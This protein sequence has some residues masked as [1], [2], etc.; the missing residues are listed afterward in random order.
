VATPGTAVFIYDHVS[1]R[2]RDFWGVT[3]R[4]DLLDSLNISDFNAQ[5]KLA[6]PAQSNRFSFRPLSLTAQY[7][8]WPK[9]VDLCEKTPISSLQEMRRGALI[10][11][12]RDALEKRMRM[13]YDPTVDWAELKALNTGLTQDAG[14]FKAKAAR[15]KLQAAEKFNPDQVAR[16][17]LYPFD[18]RWCYYTLVSPLWNRPR[19]L[20]KAQCWPGN[21]F[22]V[23]RMMA[24]RPGEGVPLS[25]TSALP[26]YH[27]LRPNAVAIPVRLCSTDAANS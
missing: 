14:G 5:Y 26:D 10:D 20:L 18:L 7:L 23:V 22:F 24:E 3:K 1:V 16:Y 9:I 12:D 17:A 2:Y 19:P 25:V 21:T 4:A 11:I 13:Y 6:Q 15:T 27:L 8:T